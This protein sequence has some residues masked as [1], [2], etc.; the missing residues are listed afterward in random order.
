M[1]ILLQAAAHAVPVTGDPFVA[2]LA[3]FADL[4]HADRALLSEVS[5]HPR[6]VGPRTDIV[7]E[8]DRAGD[9]HLIVDG[10]ACDYKLRRDGARQIVAFRVPG[11]LCD[12]DLSDLDRTS[13]AVGTLRACRVVR[14]SADALRTLRARPAIAQALHVSALVDD[15]ILRAWLL[16]LGRRTGIERIAHLFCELFARL[17]NA[18]LA[19]DGHCVLPLTQPDLA[20]TTGQ[21]SVHVNRV[22]QELRRRG[23]I[24]LRGRHL[25]LRDPA[26]LRQLAEFDPAYLNPH[27]SE[28]R[29]SGR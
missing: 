15:A 27:G 9:V 26:A 7:G 8:G 11:D 25:T 5:A 10:M 6:S 19:Q 3:R 12:L 20:D 23:L 28:N 29:L 24:D 21:T 4:S 17:Q 2:K 1:T 18:G 16:N 14:I 22:L 13:H